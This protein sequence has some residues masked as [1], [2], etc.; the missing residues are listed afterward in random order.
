MGLSLSEMRTILRR[1]CGV[2]EFDDGFDDPGC[3]EKL[4]RSY[5]N[6]LDRLNFR[7]NETTI[8]FALVTGSRKYEV[9]ADF[10]AFRGVSVFDTDGQSKPLD[11]ISAK[12]YDELYNNTATDERSNALPTKYY[13]EGNAIIL[14]PT[15]D[16]DYS[17]ILHYWKTLADLSDVNTTLP[18]QDSWHEIVLNGGVFRGYIEIGDMD[19]YAKMRAEVNALI[20]E[21]VPTEAKEERDSR[22]LHVEVPGRDYP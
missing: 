15:P 18:F 14:W 11:R 16:S 22:Y 2:D 7:E 12:V 1:S 21:Q 13:R 10:N 19:R 9:P 4:N 20:E 6:L 17:A 8:P 3:D 5:W